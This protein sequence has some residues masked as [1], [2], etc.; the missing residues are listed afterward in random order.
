M[1]RVSNG[2]AERGAEILERERDQYRMSG[3]R[4][5]YEGC[6]CECHKICHNC[7]NPFIEGRPYHVNCGDI[8]SGNTSWN[9]FG[10]GGYGA[11]KD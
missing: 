11:V 7:G 6:N 3:Y 2:W 1:N 4:K 5:P 9:Y 10:V 8:G